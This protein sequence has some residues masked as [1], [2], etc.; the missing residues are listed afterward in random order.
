M[1][2][3]RRMALLALFAL[4][5]EPAAAWGDEGHKIVGQIATHFLQ[6]AVRQQV[7]AML[8]ADPDPLTAHDF[9]SAT[10]WADRF[11]DSDRNGSQIHYLQTRQWHFTDIELADGNE[12]SACFGHP[13]IPPT[14]PASQG[15][16]K[17]CAVDRVAQYVA[18]L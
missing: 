7:I 5:V 8:A 10:T 12:D 6:P 18:A 17:N 15:P 14:L 3:L 11:R 9:V 16:A 4:P 2:I 1:N 13:V